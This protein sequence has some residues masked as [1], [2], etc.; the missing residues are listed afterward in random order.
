MLIIYPFL[1]IYLNEKKEEPYKSMISIILIMYPLI[2]IYKL[3]IKNHLNIRKAPEINEIP[4]SYIYIY[5]YIIPYKSVIKNL[6]QSK[7]TL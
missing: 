7:K 2:V 3:L 5:I 1:R 6:I 4:N